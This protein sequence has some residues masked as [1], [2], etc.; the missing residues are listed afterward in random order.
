MVL[1][2]VATHVITARIISS[3]RKAS[4][5]SNFGR[6][7]LSLGDTYNRKTEKLYGSTIF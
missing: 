5:S 2:T 6:S 7:R 3:I 4:L 1:I